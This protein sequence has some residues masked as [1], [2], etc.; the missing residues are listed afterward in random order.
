MAK[1]FQQ[2]QEQIAELKK[3]AEEMQA[4]EIRGVVARIREAIAHYG[5]TVQQ[6]FGSGARAA[7]PARGKAGKTAAP[8]GK[9]TRPAKFRDAEGNTWSGRGKRPGWFN[10][11]LAAGKSPDELLIRD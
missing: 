2:I 10:A 1:T 5:L 3:Q 7:A 4:E 6:V 11:A 8:R 9:S